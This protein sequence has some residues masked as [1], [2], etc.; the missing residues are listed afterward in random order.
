MKKITKRIS[1]AFILIFL[2]VALIYVCNI[3]N[4]P[5]NVILFEGETLKLNTIFGIDI[6]TEFT[7]NP[8]IEKI[9]NNE[10]CKR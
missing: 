3:T 1:V 2:L 10:P 6:E 5:S 8:N 7:S 4:L 9:E